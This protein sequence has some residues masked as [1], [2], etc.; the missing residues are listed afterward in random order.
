MADTFDYRK[1]YEQISRDLKNALE[2][3]ELLDA[4]IIG[5]RQ[6]LSGLEASCESLGIDIEPSREA[7]F[8][9][10]KS[11]LTEEIIKVLGATYPG[12]HRATVIKQ[13]LEQLGHE[14]S[15]YRNPLATIHM[16]LKRQIEA[17]NVE[18]NR[19]ATGEK[20]FRLKTGNSKRRS[21]LADAMMGIPRKK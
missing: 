6:T 13:K 1:A 2:E 9:R 14:L 16:I 3:R 7:I 8:I 19:N 5:I 10:E 12:Y 15:K 20:L 21:R 4:K 11:T 18:I 17:G